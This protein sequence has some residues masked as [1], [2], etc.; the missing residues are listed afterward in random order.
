MDVAR[1]LGA[2]FYAGLLERMRADAEAG[3]RCAPRWRDTS[4]TGC[5]EWDAF[6]L[7]A[8]V[9]RIVLGGQAP[10]LERALPVHRR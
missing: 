4:A 9:R 5:D 10:E 2:G 1:R 8:G 7:L 6:R 3:G